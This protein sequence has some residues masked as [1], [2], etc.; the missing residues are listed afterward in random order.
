MCNSTSVKF[1]FTI[2]LSVVLLTNCS[3]RDQ[4]VAIKFDSE[5]WQNGDRRLRGRMVDSLIDDS[6]LIGKSKSEVLTLL[7]EPT[8][9]DTGC[10]LVYVV[11]VDQK[12]FGD[13]S[14]YYLTV[15]CD[16]VSGKVTDVWCRD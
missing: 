15:Q 3:E 16:T 2:I 5:D 12:L 10:P 1:F 9:S 6:I 4:F 7:G 14:L 11:D 13:V 8:A